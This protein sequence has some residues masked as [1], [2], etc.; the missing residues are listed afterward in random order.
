MCEFWEAL[1]C[2]G[3]AFTIAGCAWWLMRNLSSEAD[4]APWEGKQLQMRR[5][6]ITGR[7][8]E[9]TLLALSR[10]ALLLHTCLKIGGRK[11]WYKLMNWQ[12]KQLK[13]AGYPAGLRVEEFWFLSFLLANVSAFIM[14]ICTKNTDWSGVLSCFAYLVGFVFPQMHLQSLFAERRRAATKELPFCLELLSLCMSAGLDFPGSLEQLARSHHGVVVRELEYV[15]LCLQM[16]MTRRVSLWELA[17]RLP[18]QSMQEWVRAMIQAEEK[19]APLGKTLAQQ[20]QMSR[21]QR[22]VRMEEQAVRA[23]VLF[24]IPL[25]MLLS[26]LLILL[27][28]PL[29]LGGVGF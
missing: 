13:W 11:Y 23:G 16:G 12:Q 3:S 29:L 22:S 20:A 21:Y 19:G 26:A 24:V 10:G 6:W 8:K 14:W 1:A 9:M 2:V 15:R 17:E 5:S 4:L 18:T 25:M 7:A 27:V 28:G